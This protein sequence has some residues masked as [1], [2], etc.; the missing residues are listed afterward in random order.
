MP[1]TC[2]GQTSAQYL[3]NQLVTTF[4]CDTDGWT[5]VNDLDE[6]CAVLNTERTDIM[7]VGTAGFIASM[8]LEDE[9]GSNAGT[10]LEVATPEDLKDLQRLVLIL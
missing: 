9:D 7:S 4:M 1:R 5:I 3:D 2:F 10:V 6:V 8:E